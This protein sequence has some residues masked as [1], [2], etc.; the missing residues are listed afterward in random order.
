MILSTAKPYTL[1]NIYKGEI[2]PT[3]SWL[4]VSKKYRSKRDSPRGLY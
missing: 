3:R 2:I 1:I 4:V